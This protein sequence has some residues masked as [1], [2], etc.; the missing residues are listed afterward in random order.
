MGFSLWGLESSVFA[1]CYF[2]VLLSEKEFPGL[3][4]RPTLITVYALWS[5]PDVKTEFCNGLLVFCVQGWF[6]DIRGNFNARVGS[7]TREEDF[8][9]HDVRG[10]HEM[11]ESDYYLFVSCH[12]YT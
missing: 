1:Y 4:S 7:T 10:F 6:A 5:C 11:N 8:V 9:W 2:R 3:C 12:V